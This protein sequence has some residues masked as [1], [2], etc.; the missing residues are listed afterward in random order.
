M[1]GLS[2]LMVNHVC[3]Y[4]KSQ[5]K[6]SCL[7][8]LVSKP[9]YSIRLNM[10]NF[11]YPKMNKSFCLSD[12][13]TS[14]DADWKCWISFILGGTCRRV[15]LWGDWLPS[16]KI[17]YRGFP[18]PDETMMLPHTFAICLLGLKVLLGSVKNMTYLTNN[19]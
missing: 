11:Y 7:S 3:H 18:T 4:H 16:A 13:K 14:C 9:C 12:S 15:L 10:E 5:S 1:G 2:K 19:W 8:V 6:D 17:D